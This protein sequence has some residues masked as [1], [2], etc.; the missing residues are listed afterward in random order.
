MAELWGNHTS[1]VHALVS[2]SS[3]AH[4]LE[5]QAQIRAIHT[6]RT[7]TLAAH[8]D[9]YFYTDVE[10]YLDQATESQMQ[11]YIDRY[12]PVIMNSIRQATKIAT[13]SQLITS[14]FPRKNESP[15][16]QN[17]M[18]HQAQEEPP[19]RKHTRRR[20]NFPTRITDFFSKVKTSTT[21]QSGFSW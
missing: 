10:Q 5:L 12:R 14:F 3:R 17:W 16:T 21:N 18:I 8:Q 1:Q 4:R 20:I 7:K 2:R 9:Q 11:R 6:L 13:N 15:R 19:H